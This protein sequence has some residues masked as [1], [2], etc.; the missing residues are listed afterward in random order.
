MWAAPVRY[1]C[2]DR[3][4]AYETHVLNHDAFMKRALLGVDSHMWS[5][6]PIFPLKVPSSM[7]SREDLPVGLVAPIFNVFGYSGIKVPDFA[8]L[9]AESGKLKLLD[10]LLTKLKKEGHRVLVYC[11]MTKM[12][13]I[14]EVSEMSDVM[15]EN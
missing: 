15:N 9:L 13:D 7:P 3:S 6:V 11:Q 8:K 14:L 4:F 12:I 2:S 10:T 5:I 1:E